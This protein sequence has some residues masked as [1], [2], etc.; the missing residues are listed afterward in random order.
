MTLCLEGVRD[1]LTRSLSFKEMN[2][3]EISFDPNW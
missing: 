1:C 2:C 3:E